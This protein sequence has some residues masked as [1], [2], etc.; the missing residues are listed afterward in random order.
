MK[1]YF[2]LIPSFCILL[3]SCKTKIYFIGNANTNAPSKTVTVYFNKKDIKVPYEIMGIAGIEHTNF[4]MVNTNKDFRKVRE[5][6]LKCGANGILYETTRV[7]NYGSYTNS[8][9]SSTFDTTSNQIV[10]STSQTVSHN[11][12][13]HYMQIYFIKYL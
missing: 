9:A 4:A 10:T 3:I 6:A 2:L 7:V 5:K 12:V 11:P 8:T 13:N 1:K